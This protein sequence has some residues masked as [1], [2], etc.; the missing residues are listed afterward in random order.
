MSILTF[1]CSNFADTFAFILSGPG[2]ADTN[3]YDHDGNPNTAPLDLDLGGLNIATIPGT[4]NVPV[5]P[6]NVHNESNCTSGLPDN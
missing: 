3:S 4:Q 6:V 1:V 2:I 5:S